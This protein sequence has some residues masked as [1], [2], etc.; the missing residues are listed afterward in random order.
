M[1]SRIAAALAA[2]VLAACGSLKGRSGAEL[3]Y[4]DVQSIHAG[5]S[6]SQVV[7]AFGKPSRSQRAPDGRVQVLD[8]VAL[9][10]KG[11]KARLFLGFD[12]REV[13]V[14]RTFTGEVQKP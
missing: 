9:D 7:D 10:A 3:S 12:D 8:Y 11:G 5:L 14:R 4:A 6:A 2:A 13:L 1:H